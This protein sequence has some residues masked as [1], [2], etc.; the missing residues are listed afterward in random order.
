MKLKP[1]YAEETEE[2]DLVL[3]A[4]LNGE[5]KCRGY[6]RGR[7]RARVGVVVEFVA[8][9]VWWFVVRAVSSHLPPCTQNKPRSQHPQTKHD[10]SIA[11]FVFG[12]L[13]EDHG[14]GDGDD[15]N[16]YFDGSGNGS[17]NGGL[18]LGGGDDGGGSGKGGGGGGALAPAPAPLG[19]GRGISASSITLTQP[20]Q[21]NGGGGK[22][23][24]RACARAFM[25]HYCCTYYQTNPP[26]THITQ[27]AHYLH[28]H[29]PAAPSGQSTTWGRA[30]G[31]A[32]ASTRSAAA[33]RATSGT[34]SARCSCACAFFLVLYTS[35]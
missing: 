5:G 15:D 31:G 10:G 9:I 18:L 26:A 34:R 17:G 19:V 3:L 22:G 28:P 16:A 6:V 33:P 24:V 25:W 29:H 1:D 7:A 23:C 11:R 21:R 35:F 30:P 20:T 12:V 4:G 27:N 32:S 13:A 14:A 8:A 2:L